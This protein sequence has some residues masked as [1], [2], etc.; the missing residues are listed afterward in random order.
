MRGLRPHEL[1]RALSQQPPGQLYFCVGEE[2]YVAAE[3]LDLLRGATI[4]MEDLFNYHRFEAGETPIDEIIAAAA[5]LPIFAPR[6]LV[7]LTRAEALKTDEQEALAAALDAPAPT[8]CLVIIAA[9]ADQRRRLFSSLPQRAVVIN[10]QPLLERELPAWLNG[11]AA[12][13]ELQLAPEVVHALIEQ[14][15]TSLHALVNEMEKL[16]VYG[17]ARAEALAQPGGEVTLLKIGLEALAQLTAHG[18]QHSV[19]ELTDAAGERRLADA[20]VI[21]RHLLDEGEQPVGLVAVLTRHLRRLWLAKG[22]VDQGDT[23]AALAKRLGVMPRYAESLTRQAAGF[24]APHLQR[25]LTRCVVADAQLKGGRLPKG[26]VIESLLIEV[27]RG[28]PGPLMVTP[29]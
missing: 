2:P 6:R 5:T 21:V 25:L 11:Q 24:G 16:R 9:K 18:R 19:F 4:G 22:G 20:L 23:P 17:S 8:T 10:C 15:G 3:A 28:L 14:T 7:V 1:R 27:C 26:Q 13:L 29:A 12:A